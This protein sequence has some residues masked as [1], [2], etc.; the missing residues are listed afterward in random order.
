MIK[1]IKLICFFS[2]LGMFGACSKTDAVPKH[3]GVW[4]V[5]QTQTVYKNDV[6]TAEYIDIAKLTL[7][8]DNQ[9]N[10]EYSFGVN[11]SVNWYYDSKNK[12][13]FL[14]IVNK[15]SS[16]TQSY[17]N[18]VFDITTDNTN[19]QVWQREQTFLSFQTQ[20]KQRTVDYWELKKK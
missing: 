5:S 4:T 3:T 19:E 2:I 15:F 13:F 12:K 8:A 1:T 20:E 10:I 6:Q 16:G 17:N 9:G 14:S 7:T 11:S 18:I